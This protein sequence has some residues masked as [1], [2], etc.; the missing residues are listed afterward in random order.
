M[1]PESSSTDFSPGS[2]DERWIDAALSEHARLGHGDDEELVF[3]ILQETVHRPLRSPSRT[4]TVRHWRPFMVAA[5]SIAASVALAL[6]L[7]PRQAP[8]PDER[9]SDELRFVV[10]M[11]SPEAP[12]SNGKTPVQPRIAATRHT[13]PFELTAPA[14]SVLP[15]APAL[16]SGHFE[17][18][19]GFAPS[20][21]P[22][23][24]T[25][26]V[27][28]RL[29]ITADR[30]ESTGSGMIYEGDVLVEHDAFRIEAATVRVS[31]PGEEET[32][33]A[34]LLAHR[35]RVVRPASGCVAEAETLRFDP[36]S[37]R[38]VLTGVTRVESA[39]GQLD[40]FA[41]GDR[42]IL[43]ESGFSVETAPVERY[44]SPLPRSR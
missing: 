38:L 4:A 21:S 28:E 33:E 6:V 19:S 7:L 26:A 27:G 41:P 34:P 30:G 36:A 14:A 24:R 32:A 1:N 29:R 25:E 5:G 35:V 16:A 40:Q 39:K 18:V 17:W 3:R 15:E 23:P 12:P 31:V 8:T 22:Q 2:A 37:G 20:F 11:A 42:L 10:R 13:G 43:S 44:A 9:R